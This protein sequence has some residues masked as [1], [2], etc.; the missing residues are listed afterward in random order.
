MSK[1]RLIKILEAPL[2]SEKSTN[3]EALGQYAFQVKRD[4]TKPEI[5]NAIKL[6][7]NVDVE[8]IRVCNVI[9][10]KRRFGN[11][12]GRRKSWKKAYVTLKEGQSIKLGGA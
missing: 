10:K 12:I 1:E 11:S 6:M 4:A 2:V 7:F 9:G 3:I 8:T 5:A